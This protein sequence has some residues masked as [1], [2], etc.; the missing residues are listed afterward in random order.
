MLTNFFVVEFFFLYILQTLKTLC[1]LT[2]F[3]CP[4][5]FLSS[6]THEKKE[7]NKEHKKKINNTNEKKKK[8]EI[9]KKSSE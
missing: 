4:K 6:H 7:R 9:K 2:N 1:D 3:C 5:V 8:K